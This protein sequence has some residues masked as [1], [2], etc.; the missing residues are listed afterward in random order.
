MAVLWN[1]SLSSSLYRHAMS[2][3][4][5]TNNSRHKA[6]E[7]SRP[8]FI[9]VFPCLHYPFYLDTLV[10]PVSQARILETWRSKRIHSPLLREEL[11]CGR[12]IFG[13]VI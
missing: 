2:L 7:R 3:K 8:Q 6:Q 5:Y 12:I 13:P 9:P 1:T 10:P 11:G 4:T